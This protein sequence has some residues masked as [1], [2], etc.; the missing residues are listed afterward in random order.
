MS[1]KVR[2]PCKSSEQSFCNR[3]EAI[4]SEAIQDRIMDEIQNLGKNPYPYGRKLFKKLKV[5]VFL[6]NRT[7]D[8]RIR[9]GNYRVLYDV[10]DKKKVVYIL[11][12]R[13]RSE[14]TYR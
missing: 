12:L 10:D 7:A 3:L 5:P 9:V 13:A 11:A 6:F 8:H 1:Y 4:P 14:K 2:F